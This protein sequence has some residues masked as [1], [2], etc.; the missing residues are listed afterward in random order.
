MRVES[1][2]G[3]GRFRLQLRLRNPRRYRIDATHPL[4]FN[5]RLWSLDVKD[6]EA[7]LVDYLQKIYCRYQSEIE[8]EALALG[9]FSFD[10][11]PRLLL[12]YL[13]LLPAAAGV[14]VRGERLTYRDSRGRRWSAWLEDGLVARWTLWRRQGKVEWRTDGEW[15][16]LSAADEGLLVRWRQTVREESDDSLPSVSVPQEYSEGSCDLGWIKGV[17][18]THETRVG[19]RHQREVAR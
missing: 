2:D 16:T 5:R 7:L 9:P 6:D 19:A 11:L 13:P 17:T 15:A 14:R 12:G 3:R 10:S 18:N 4:L 1:P 8:I